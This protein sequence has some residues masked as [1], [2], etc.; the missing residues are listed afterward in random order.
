MFHSAQTLLCFTATFI[1]CASTMSGMMR[2]VTF[3]P[4]G[5]EK[6]GI[7]SVPIPQLREKEV[8]LKVYATAINRADTLQRKGLYPA[9]PGESDIL[10]LEAVGVIEKLGPGCVKSWKTGDRVMALL[11]GGGNAEYVASREELLMPVPDNMKFTQ[12]AA[13]PEVWLTAFQLLFTVGKLK[14]NDTVLIH[15]GGSGVGTAAVQLCRQYGARALV[16]AGTQEKIDFAKSLGAEEGFNYKEAEFEPKVLE[17]TQGKGVDLILDCVGG[18][19]FNQNINSIATEGT[20]VVYGLMGGSTV[21]TGDHLAKILRK[22][23]TIIGSTLRA[24]SVEYKELLISDF[25]QRALPHFGSSD[26][27]PIIHTVLTLDSIKEAHQLMESNV[28]TG[29]IVLQVREESTKEE[30]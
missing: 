16:V 26:L 13:I 6:L 14:K 24:R 18:S 10:G 11:P 21:S 7:A 9:P 30:L 19:F 12:A 27:R 3:E 20:W 2:A 29:K 1:R 23:I 17:H 15:A 28:T 5:P 8:L 25:T 4:G 22:R